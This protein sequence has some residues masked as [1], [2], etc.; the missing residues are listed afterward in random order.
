MSRDLEAF[1]V[2]R[3]VRD[4]VLRMK[5]AAGQAAAPSDYWEE[6]LSKIDYMIEASPLIIG[7]LRHHAFH[8]TGIHPHDY[9]AQGDGQREAF[10]ERLRALVELGGRELLVPE[11]PAL[12]G[13]GY[14]LSEGLFNRDTIKFFE[15]LVGMKRGGVLAA[16]ERGVPPVVL[17][18]G[19]G[20]GGFAYQLK[21]LFP[22][23]TYV[24]VD[25]P[26][27]FLFS[28]TYLQTVFPGARIVFADEMSDAAEWRGADF[29]FVP[30]T[31]AERVRGIVP[32]V[33]INMASFQELTSEQ[34]EGYARLASDAGSP[35]LYSFNR[36]ASSHNPQIS[37]VSEQAGKYYDL[38]EVP[39]LET[40]YPK[41]MKKAAKAGKNVR[42]GKSVG[43]DCRAYRHLVGTR[44]ASDA[45]PSAL[46]GPPAGAV[47]PRVAIGATLYNRAPYLHEALDSILAQTYRGFSLVLV[48]D[49]SS[50][51]TEAIAREYEARDPR[52]RYVRH[53]ERQGMTSTWRHAFE[54]A[55][56]SPGVR[57]FAWASDHDR[58]DP[59][60]LETLVGEME[61]DANL[62]LAYPFTRRLDPGGRLLDKPPRLFDTRGM[63]TLDE[64][65]PYVCGEH[66]ASGDMVYGLMSVD[67][68]RKAG[69]FRDVI[70]PDR[71]LMAELALQGEFQ[72]VPKALWF[73][74]QFDGASVARQGATLFA[75]R[76]P[77]GRWQPPWLQHGRALW[78]AYVSG[79]V[80]PGQ[81]RN[82]ARRVLQYSALYALKHQQ[83]TTTY[84]QIGAAWRGLVWTRKKAKHYTLLGLYHTLVSMRR[85]YHRTVYE[86]AIFTR[87]IGLR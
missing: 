15:V 78:Q 59:R 54:E 11:H 42:P 13:F 12:G 44:R 35:L 37:S 56:A 25:L 24:I 48:D 64:R 30:H 33:T 36:E 14:Q 45:R 80:D 86:V 8:I 31:M 62:V 10:E 4:A 67:A 6:D 38:G 27:L 46:S 87:R 83:K 7:K 66:V 9:R 3:R 79:V 71:L 81:R 29:V 43:A 55:T 51:G 61:A 23:V 72:Q 34:V 57:Y 19:A 84:R 75:G 32:D 60:W 39:V 49:G 65:W 18:I 52:V 47:G 22:G 58:W 68:V 16:L 85:A 76:A 69:I 40:D 5:G 63:R 2:Y 77:R 20:W 50:D 28:A 73:R 17:E 26:E 82:A 41:A 1:E 74:R 53:T 21:T 70:C